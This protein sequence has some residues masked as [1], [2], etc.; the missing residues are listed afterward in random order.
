MITETDKRK[1]QEFLKG[2]NWATPDW[3][4]ECQ[5]TELLDVLKAFNHDPQI[6]IDYWNVA[7]RK[8]QKAVNDVYRKAAQD[9]GFSLNK[10][11]SKEELLRYFGGDQE[12]VNRFFDEINAKGSQASR[13][14]FHDN[15]TA[16]VKHMLNQKNTI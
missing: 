7:D 5:L 14:V 13:Q 9:L 6:A 3:E 2:T 16:V 15:F 1:I 4:D 10:K 8:A 12:A 11:I